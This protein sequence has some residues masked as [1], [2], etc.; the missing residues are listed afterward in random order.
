VETLA[1]RAGVPLTPLLLPFAEGSP[2]TYLELVQEGGEELLEESLRFLSAAA[3]T[4]WRVFADYAGQGPAAAGLEETLKVLHFLLRM[5]RVHESLKAHHGG[6]GVP[7]GAA[8]GYR[9]TAQALEKEGWDASLA[10]Y[11]GPFE[12]VADVP[13]FAA[14]LEAAHRA[15]KGYSKPQVALI[16]LFL[17]YEAGVR[18]A[19]AAAGQNARVAA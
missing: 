4:D 7:R 5:V 10:A 15:V 19:A 6:E 11:L 18:K 1:A 13:A 14:C 3:S 9:W 2:G 16:G 12:D 8:D 17:E